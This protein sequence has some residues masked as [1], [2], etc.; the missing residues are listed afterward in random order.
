MTSLTASAN[1][2]T[3]LVVGAAFLVLGGL[4]FGA[5]LQLPFSDPVGVLLFTT[6]ST[7]ALLA[8]VQL[9]IGAALVIAALVSR[10]AARMTTRVIGALLLVLGLAGLFLSSTP[11]NWLAVNAAANLVHFTAAA[12]LLAV[13]L[14]TDREPAR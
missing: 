9:L 5:A 12:V 6:I 2:V 13:G 10:T 7:N 11:Q 4:S 1:R 8:T 14:G 3:A